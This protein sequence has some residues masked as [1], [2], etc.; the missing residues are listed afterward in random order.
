MPLPL[1][2]TQV[3]LDAESS[4]NKRTALQVNINEDEAHT[5]GSCRGGA[6]EQFP[7][8][9]VFDS[10]TVTFNAVGSDVLHVMGYY[11]MTEGQEFDSDEELE[12]SD[13]DNE[14]NVMSDQGK[15]TFEKTSPQ[16]SRNIKRVDT[17]K[18]AAP[19]P[20]E[21]NKRKSNEV[22]QSEERD[23]ERAKKA[24]TDKSAKS[25]KS[26]PNGSPSK[27]EGPTA[28]TIRGMKMID[29]VVGNGLAPTAGQKIGVKYVGR[30]E[31]N[32]QVFDS[33]LNKPFVFRIGV[34]DVI[35]GWDLGVRDM[36]VG[37]KRKLIIPPELAYG[38]KKTGAIPAN[39]TLVFDVELCKV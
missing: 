32:G 26:T 24:K 20:K 30:F 33:C 1:H 11:I 39:S 2:L 5:V 18:K 4:G 14:E 28:R 31:K 27:E 35:K 25:P 21:K 19:E 15:V 6:V 17:P 29:L 9:L 8:D 3:A 38:N 12:F 34:G 7:L 16:Q 22:T 37:G 10:D 13:E 36:R 23:T